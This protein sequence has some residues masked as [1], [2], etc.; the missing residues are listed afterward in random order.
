MKKLRF[1]R[2]VLAQRWG[3]ALQRIP[4]DPGFSCPH[5]GCTFCASNGSRARHLTEGM[6]IA[7]QVERGKQYVHDRYGSDGPYIAYFQAFTG[8]NAPVEQIRAVYEEALRLAD[9]KMVIIGTRPDCLP[10]EC[11]DYLEE[12]NQRY[13]NEK[14][15]ARRRAP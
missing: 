5:S 4:L 15:E 12:L 1:F 7:E 9:F 11:L 8:T 13:E 10:E 3:T 6:T 2:D 14:K